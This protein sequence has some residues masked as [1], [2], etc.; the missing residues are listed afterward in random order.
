MEAADSEAVES[1]HGFAGLVRYLL[2][3]HTADMLRQALAALPDPGSDRWEVFFAEH[4][5][6]VADFIGA[7]RDAMGRPKTLFRTE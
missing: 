6:V 7:W 2:T 1:A 3:F 5:A 4:A